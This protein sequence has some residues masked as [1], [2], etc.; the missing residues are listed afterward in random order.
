V[1][2]HYVNGVGGRRRCGESAGSLCLA[3]EIVLE[4]KKK[5]SHRFCGLRKKCHTLVLPQG[6]LGEMKERE[7]PQLASLILAPWA[8][9]K[10][11][12]CISSIAA[13]S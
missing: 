7:M 11:D 4:K 2:C 10:N 12:I 3:G 9:E 13:F 1:Y 5:G 6:A 8:G